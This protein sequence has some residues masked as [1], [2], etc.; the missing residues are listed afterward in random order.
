MCVCVLL[1]HTHISVE[2]YALRIIRKYLPH[3]SWIILNDADELLQSFH[4][5]KSWFI[6]CTSSTDSCIQLHCIQLH[7]LRSI[8]V[9][10]VVKFAVAYVTRVAKIFK[11]CACIHFVC[12]IAWMI[13]N[14]W[15]VGVSLW[16]LIFLYFFCF[17][18]S[19]YLCANWHWQWL[20][21]RKKTI[22]Y[23]WNRY[24][25]L[26]TNKINRKFCHYHFDM[27]VI[28]CVCEHVFVI[29]S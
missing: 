8:I 19:Y 5:I 28:V 10:V 15:P 18:L 26:S 1:Y 14:S 22:R 24:D 12:I 11:I 29:G 2:W 3:S 21:E 25:G 13:A 9:T 4:L 20:R 23:K 6:E 17:H 7:E 16:P 27:F